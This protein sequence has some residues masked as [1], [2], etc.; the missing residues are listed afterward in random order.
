MKKPK[1]KQHSRSN[2][3]IARRRPASNKKITIIPPRKVGKR[4]LADLATRINAAHKAVS[5]YMRRGLREAIQTGHLLLE[6]KARLKHGQ[7]LPW[8]HKHCDV[9]ERTCHVYMRLAEHEA[10]IGN[11]ADITDFTVRGAIALIAKADEPAESSA[12]DQDRIVSSSTVA[13]AR[14]LKLEVT[15]QT[16]AIPAVGYV[17]Q[18]EHAN[19]ATT[20][21]C[22]ST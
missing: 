14:P 16:I 5:A 11:V 8:L 21:R 7:W 2:K 9:P 4:S 18:D 22:A 1:I 3:K 15:T 13:P 6:A 20:K 10:E 17:H 19:T 12:I